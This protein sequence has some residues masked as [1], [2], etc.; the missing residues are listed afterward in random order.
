[1]TR[2]MPALAVCLVCA[3]PPAHAQTMTL[4]L[5]PAKTRVEFTL[6]A[7]LHTVRGTFKL[8]R[9]D[10]RI[11]PLS[12]RASGELV[13]DAASGESGNSARDG[14]MHKS[15]LESASFPE[16]GFTP[17]RFDGRLS[18]SGDSQIQLHG[19]FSIHGGKHEMVLPVKVRVQ[20]QELDADTQ[21]PVPYQ[22]WGMK[23]PSTFI[24]HVDDTVQ[25]H[26]HAV[27]R[28]SPLQ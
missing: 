11:D 16:I 24:L 3:M 15:V 18:L 23:N 21:F 25:I 9:G 4:Q 7:T 2:F 12:G 17:D 14:R 19:V 6:G 8:K 5:D 13:I 10:L 28:L 22:K 1:M 26:I 27:G 20:Q